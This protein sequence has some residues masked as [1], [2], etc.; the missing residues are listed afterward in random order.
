MTSS[1]P[2]LLLRVLQKQQWVHEASPLERI[3]F[4]LGCVSSLSGISQLL[5]GLLQ[6][7]IVLTYSCSLLG[8][9]LLFLMLHS[10][11]PLPLNSILYNALWC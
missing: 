9:T 10:L 1:K 5:C 6:L 3:H 4:Q 7:Q 11:L 8:L 2:L